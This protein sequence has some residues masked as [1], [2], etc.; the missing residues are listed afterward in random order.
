MT[1]RFQDT[2]ACVNRRWGGYFPLV[3][4]AIV[5][6]ATTSLQSAD[7]SG[8]SL[9]LID[10]VVPFEEFG[11][12]L[13]DR[14]RTLTEV[15]DDSLFP[16]NL[17]REAI[18][19]ARP[20]DDVETEIPERRSIFGNDRFLSPGPI[21]EGIVL[22]T[23]ATWRPSFL[24]F[25]NL[26]SAVQS[27]EG[28]GGERSTEWANRLDIFGNLYLSSTERFLIGFRPLDE[29]GVFTGFAGGPGIGDDGFQ[30]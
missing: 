23:G 21:D 12:E 13:T 11:A 4:I 16:E 28:V 8:H 18:L 9:G 1:A 24:I 15:I 2:T 30:N 25:G 14:E 27:Y 26:R 6:T 17:A 5:G 29:E 7:D 3:A 22:P 19:E 20:V 10:E